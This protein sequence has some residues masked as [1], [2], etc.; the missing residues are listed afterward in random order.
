MLDP[1]GIWRSHVNCRDRDRPRPPD[2]EHVLRWL[3]R[4]PA[5]AWF[6]G[7]RRIHNYIRYVYSWHAYCRSLRCKDQKLGLASRVQ[8][9]AFQQVRQEHQEPEQGSAE[10]VSAL[11]S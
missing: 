1:G 9:H 2:S 5:L 11:P 7:L 4:R 8:R 10:A 3:W 6:W